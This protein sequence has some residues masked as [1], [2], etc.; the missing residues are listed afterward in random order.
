[1]VLMTESGEPRE[2]ANKL[3]DDWLQPRYHKMN[4]PHIRKHLLVDAPSG[5]F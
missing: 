2:F 1:V 4:R 3:L 5:T